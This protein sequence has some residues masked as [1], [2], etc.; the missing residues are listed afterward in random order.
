MA[1]TLFFSVDA[2]IPEDVLNEI[3]ILYNLGVGIE[4]L[5]YLLNVRLDK[6]L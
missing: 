2:D 4:D 5:K 3:I 1:K 6:L